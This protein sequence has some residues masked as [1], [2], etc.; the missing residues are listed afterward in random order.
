MRAVLIVGTLEPT[1][2]GIS[3]AIRDQV[4]ELATQ[5]DVN[6][7]NTGAARRRRPNS[8]T[9]ENLL[10]V[11]DHARAVRRACRKRPPDIVD[12]HTVGSPA[13]PL[14][15]CLLLAVA[16]G[17]PRRPVVVH[18]HG[19]QHPSL[20]IAWRVAAR[21]I[22][23]AIALDE[24]VAAA[25][26]RMAPN[27]VVHVL[28]NCVRP[29]DYVVANL[30]RSGPVQLVFVGTVGERKGVSELLSA[31]DRLQRD[32]SMVFVGGAGEEG[33]AANRRVRAGA[34]KLGRPG[35]V[36]FMGE[37]DRQQVRAVLNASDV[38]VLPSRAEGM[39][40]ALLEA[41]ATGLPTVVCDSGTM[42]R[43]VQ[44]AGCGFVV[45]VGD[46]DALAAAL[47]NVLD[48]SGL[49]ARL[50]AAGR[51]AIVANYSCTAL[52]DRLQ[53]VYREALERGAGDDGG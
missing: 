8:V 20:G 14:L 42:G 40:I 53:A 18:I 50:G 34:D 11:F 38:F 33:I 49:R 24:D 37:V 16:A 28:P 2:G 46:V 10:A 1:V 9:M 31:V 5:W 52:V 27:L 29:D 3:A 12:V 35:S 43:V 4:E 19:Y 32:V 36:T 51:R 6:V 21:L 17:G 30:D 48:D 47:A 13:L 22:A 23:A 41:M 25:L 39:P 45:P 15:R 7:V 26:R 44:D